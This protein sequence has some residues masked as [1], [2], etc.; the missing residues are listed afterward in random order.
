MVD[1]NLSGAIYLG[2]DVGGQ[3]TNLG[4]GGLIVNTV[5]MIGVAGMPHHIAYVASKHGVVGLTRALAGEWAAHEI[6]V[7]ALY[8]G[9]THTEIVRHAAEQNPMMAAPGVQRA[10]RPTGHFRRAGRVRLLSRLG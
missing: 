2:Q 10:A 9:P 6:R 5:S 7:N 4:H 1:V 8:P 3:M